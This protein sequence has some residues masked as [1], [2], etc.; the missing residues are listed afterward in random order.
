MA[1]PVLDAMA[2][3]VISGVVQNVRG[4]AIKGD[5]EVSLYGAG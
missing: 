1:I 3:N 2:K 4:C 5:L